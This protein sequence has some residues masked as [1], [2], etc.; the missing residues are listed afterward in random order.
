LSPSEKLARKVL[1]TAGARQTSA[2]HG[3]SGA[4]ARPAARARG[5][6]DIPPE[7][8][9]AAPVE[10]R[11]SAAG[12][13]FQVSRLGLGIV[14]AVIGLGL[15]GAYL[16]LAGKAKGEADPS[17]LVPL[18][19]AAGAG[20]AAVLVGAFN[21]WKGGETLKQVFGALAVA[22]GLFL[23]G[24]GGPKFIS[25]CKSKAPAIMEGDAGGKRIPPGPPKKDAPAKPGS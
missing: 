24:Y 4:P 10:G 8:R 20:L 12:G 13:R 17:A 7:F 16:W 19:L 2:G 11:D 25:E 21:V 23:A 9:N 18:G 22:A 6:P 3:A 14:F 15:Y 1:S 5:L